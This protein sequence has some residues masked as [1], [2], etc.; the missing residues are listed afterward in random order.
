M[1]RLVGQDGI[2]RRLGK[3]AKRVTNPPCRLPTCP[4]IVEGARDRPFAH[5]S[6]M[7][8]SWAFVKPREVSYVRSF[9]VGDD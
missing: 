4:T 6:V 1:A 9:Q 3:P 7:L 5:A 2:L 8:E